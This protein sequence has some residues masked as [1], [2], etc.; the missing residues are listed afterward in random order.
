MN[1][2]AKPIIILLLTIN[3]YFLAVHYKIKQRRQYYKENLAKVVLP[4]KK[5]I[6]PHLQPKPL[7]LPENQSF[8]KSKFARPNHSLAQAGVV[9]VMNDDKILWSK[10]AKKSLPIASLT[11]IITTLHILDIINND[12]HLSLQTKIPITSNS[13]R[14]AHSSFLRRSPYKSLSIET[15]LHSVMFRSANDSAQLLADYFGGNKKYKMPFFV[16]LNRYVRKEGCK[17]SYFYNPHGLPGK[18]N[19][20]PDNKMSVENLAHLSKKLLIK[21]P[22]VTKWTKKRKHTYFAKSTKKYIGNNTNSLTKSLRH[23]TGLKT[24]YTTNSG[25]CVVFSWKFGNKHCLA[26]LL[27]CKNKKTRTKLAKDIY[28]WTNRF[29][30]TNR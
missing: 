7:S 23:I 25:Y 6:V 11:K 22:I 28:H 5:P 17:N 12:Q 30:V 27:G 19:K 9:L 29:L 18:Y 8:I 15:L 24:G 2:F 4:L 26:I 1:K 3:C 13:K 20:K 14:V 16:Q 21:Y 10:N